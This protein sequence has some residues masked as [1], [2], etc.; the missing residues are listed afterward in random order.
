M[1][2]GR[3]EAKGA[4]E[5]DQRRVINAYIRDLRAGMDGSKGGS[6][7]SGKTFTGK[8]AKKQRWEA[9]KS[10]RMRSRLPVVGSERLF[11]SCWNAQV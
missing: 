8:A 7:G 4:R 9:Y 11:Y 10:A 6:R 3:R 2:G 1:H 5:S